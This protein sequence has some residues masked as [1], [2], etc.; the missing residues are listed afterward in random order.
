V[1]EKILTKH[2]GLASLFKIDVY[3][4]NDGYSSVK[5]ALSGMKPDE[6]LEEVKAA[7]LRGRGGAGFPAGVKWGFVPKDAEKSK[8]LCVNADEGEPGTFKDRYIMNHNPHLLIEGIII[9][10]YCV[11]INKVWRKPYPRH[12]TKV[13]LARISWERGLNW[14]CMSIGERVPIFVE[15]KRLF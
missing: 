11:G 9:S 8:Y 15:K 12:M 2:F 7:N 3:L 4:E 6:I 1:A 14:M 13:F 10:S 5:K